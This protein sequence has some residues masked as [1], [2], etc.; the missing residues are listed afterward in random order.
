MW[1]QDKDAY[2]VWMTE[3]IRD[4]VTTVRSTASV[5]R[6][7][8]GR[9]RGGRAGAG[10]H[11]GGRRHP[12]RERREGAA[13]RRTCTVDVDRD[14]RG[15]SAGRLAR[16]TEE[17]SMAVVTKPA[18][19]TAAARE[20]DAHLRQRGRRRGAHAGRHRRRHRVPDPA[21]RHVMQ[22]IAKKIASGKLVAEYIVAE[23]EH[24][25]FEIV[26]HASTVGARVF[27]GPPAWAGCT[28][29]RRSRSPRPARPHG[30]AGGEPRARRP[31]RVRRGAQR[32]AVGARP[33]LAP[34]LD[35]HLPGGARHDADRVPRG[36]GPAGVPADR[37]LGGRR[38]P[39]ALPGAH[40]GA[41]RSGRRFLPRTTGAT[42][43][44][45]RQPDHGG[46]P[47]NEDWVIE[48]R[49]QNDEATGART[50]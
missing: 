21:L 28:R 10:R 25:Q 12:G 24:S 38:V 35:R 3:K 40:P 47:G 16:R 32:R 36:G 27:C 43:C 2:R 37:D 50:G 23:G 46:A 22:A 30:G 34:V 42:S 48:I 6:P 20:G 39:H 13:P 41:D 7:V 45:T 19:G 15:R 26:K 14:R 33:G 8:R 18:G 4:K 11:P 44:C 17:D 1:R 31:G 9:A 5:P 29:W 49:R